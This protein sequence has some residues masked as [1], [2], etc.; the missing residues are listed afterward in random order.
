MIKSYIRIALRRLRNNKI[1]SF[2]SLSSLTIGLLSCLLTLT[3]ILD[4]LSYDKFWERKDDI[5]RIVSV[6]NKGEAVDKDPA[7]FSNLGTALKDNFPE[8]ESAGMVRKSGGDL[9]TKHIRLKKDQD[10]MSMLVIE[11]D[12][13]V[14]QTL[15]LTYLEGQPQRV[16]EG[17]ANLIV[18]ESFANKHFPG[19]SATGEIIYGI[20]SYSNTERPYM[21]TGVINDIPNN[22]YLHAEA[23]IRMD[24]EFPA[25]QD[26]GSGFYIEQLI[27]LNSR[28]D[29][30]SFTEKINQ[31]YKSY[32]KNASPTA[33]SNLPQYEFQPIGDIYLNPLSP[34]QATSGN[35]TNIY[36][37][38]LT[39]L[40]LLLTA[41]FNYV[42]MTM[43]KELKGRKNSGVLKVLGAERK[44]IF[45][46]SIIETCL[47]FAL[48]ALLA[49]A[50]YWLTLPF[51]EQFFNY[52]FNVA[53]FGADI[54]SIVLTGCLLLV[55]GFTALYPA[56]IA[57]TVNPI[58]SLKG[59]IAYTISGSFNWVKQGLVVL[60]FA[61]ATFVIIATISIWRQID[62]VKQQ[63]LGYNPE[64]VLHIS[65]FRLSPNDQSFINELKAL[66]G[67][68]QVSKSAWYPTGF[69]G[70]RSR[71]VE[72]PYQADGKLDIYYIEGDENLSSLLDFKLLKGRLL[73]Q[74]DYQKS[75]QYDD[76]EL[77]N[78]LLT[79]STAKRLGIENLDVPHQDLGIIPVGIIADFHAVSLH[80]PI[81][82]TVITA[83]GE[84]EVANILIKTNASEQKLLVSQIENLYKKFYPVLP[85][86]M[87]RVTDLIQLQYKNE[88]KQQKLLVGFG[89]VTLS[90]AILGIF[91]LAA[92]TNQQRIK[93][94]GIRKVLG[95]SIPNIIWLLSFSFLKLVLLAAVLASPIAWLASNKWLAYF[96]YRVNEH[97]WPFL[98]ATLICV[99]ISFLTVGF[100]A[101]RTAKNNPVNSLRD[102]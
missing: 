42:N 17:H 89:L 66:N 102:E 55:C 101:G 91:G 57:S 25:L 54:I 20:S 19:K 100:L 58:K 71:K 95:A 35:K 73:T 30:K 79:E 45:T 96:S 46:Q 82:P 13:N 27:L 90:L 44:S 38:G 86:Q 24:N 18:T 52:S 48:A 33:L 21:I 61:M 14:I 49:F 62:Y 80:K 2:I 16:P 15:S 56:M 59:E 36:I 11:A 50:L 28:T 7:A 98:L 69:M 78:A 23:I 31:W 29:I 88:D 4:E 68:D 70:N 67:I 76:D 51:I 93:E 77:Q 92:Y 34:S 74:R 87:H 40:L 83:T 10:P 5:Y 12:S 99:V 3:F 72:D 43:S 32:V 1:Y 81:V 84:I 6:H 85:L 41:C 47:H 8:V 65:A 97:W 64:N 9:S 75:S 26:D 37:F 63:K 60:Q 53:L 22:S 39:S 94:I